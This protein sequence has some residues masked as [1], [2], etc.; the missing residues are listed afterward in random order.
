MVETNAKAAIVQR[1]FEGVFDLPD[2]IYVGA[3]A[4]GHCF[5]CSVRSRTFDLI[6]PMLP[7]NPHDER[8]LR[9]PRKD[10]RLLVPKYDIWGFI[11]GPRTDW[12]SD[13]AAIV[14]RFECDD[15]AD[16]GQI[17][18]DFG[19]DLTSWYIIATQWLE[20]WARQVLAPFQ[21]EEIITTGSMWEMNVTPPARSSWRSKGH[22]DYVPGKE[23]DR[24]MLNT[25]F[26]HASRSNLPPLEWRLYLGATRNRDR[27]IAVIEAVSAV[28]MALSNALA[29]R[30][31][32]V[33]SAAM[34][35]IKQNAN[36]VLG[37][38]R[39][40][41]D[42]DE[43]PA[44][45]HQWR[46]VADR[47]AEPRNQATHRGVAPTLEVVSQVLREARKLLDLYS[48]LPSPPE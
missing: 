11:N 48:P 1:I 7:T 10:N 23:A 27:R 20:L 36:G 4:L 12:A 37:I 41:E 17:A 33:P 34:S 24:A 14:F 31:P 44:E 39:L 42:I 2:T 30:L 46:R 19:R 22:I 3:D 47:L 45:R 5:S 9:S 6:F 32:Q 15:E 16:G 38:L 13:V 18:Y 25:A 29:I 21:G 43:T 40:I 8:G 26:T 28:E 35:R